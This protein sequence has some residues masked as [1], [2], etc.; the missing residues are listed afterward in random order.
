[1]RI[2]YV[3]LVEFQSDEWPLLKSVT[4]RWLQ[5]SYA[6]NFF[7]NGHCTTLTD[8]QHQYQQEN[9]LFKGHGYSKLCAPHLATH[10]IGTAIKNPMARGCYGYLLVALVGRLLN[11]TD[12]SSYALAHWF[13]FSVDQ[14]S[15]E[16]GI[17]QFSTM[18]TLGSYLLHPVG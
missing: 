9:M 5:R 6:V 15:P 12:K 18:L 11:W 8:Y 7:Q 13:A 3:L 16:N 14:V 4:S 1:M 17:V 2:K 10:P